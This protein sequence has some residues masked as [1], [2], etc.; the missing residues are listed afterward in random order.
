MPS[1]CCSPAATAASRAMSSSRISAA[2]AL[3]TRSAPAHC[4]RTSSTAR[5]FLRSTVSR[6]R[7]V[8]PCSYGMTNVKWLTD[9]TVIDAAF[10]GYQ[11]S[12]SYACAARSVRGR[13]ASDADDASFADGPCGVPVLPHETRSMPAGECTLTGRA[14]SGV[15]EIVT[16]EVTQMAA[17]PGSMPNFR[18]RR[19]R[20]GCGGVGRTCGTPCRSPR[21]C[22]GRPTRRRQP[23]AHPG[24]LE[25]RWLHEQRRPP[26]TG[27]GPWLTSAVHAFDHGGSHAG[28]QSPNA[29]EK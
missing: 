27:R 8:V 12:I 16:V 20:A 26:G 10:D 18:R 21:L 1:R 2:S 17:R 4:W 11:Q 19:L 9:I 13:H 25:R 5:P 6:S 29:E 7:L 28:R 24:G 23:A 14:W 22:R 3:A 15:A